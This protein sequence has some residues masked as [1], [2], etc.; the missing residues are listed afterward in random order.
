MRFR[1]LLQAVLYYSDRVT[2]KVFLRGAKIYSFRYPRVYF[3]ISW[4]DVTE[5]KRSMALFD[6]WLSS[7]V[8]PPFSPL[9][10]NYVPLIPMRVLGLHWE[11]ASDLPSGGPE[12]K[13]YTAIHVWSAP[14]SE[15]WPFNVRSRKLEWNE[16]CRWAKW[17]W[18]L[19][20]PVTS[21]IRMT[22]R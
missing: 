18:K 10:K 20:S 17:C 13:F 11:T 7:K 9:Q 21:W 6:S 19:S 15:A 5:R 14:K 8:T 1:L 4:F 16:T 3:I 22:K 12:R 2:K